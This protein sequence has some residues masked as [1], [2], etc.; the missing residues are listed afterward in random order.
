MARRALLLVAGT[1]AL[2]AA[3]AGVLGR[4][5]RRGGPETNGGRE[6]TEELRREIEAARARLRES[7]R[8]KDG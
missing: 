6:R 4:A 5:R 3:I 2:A 8:S 7:I 1:A